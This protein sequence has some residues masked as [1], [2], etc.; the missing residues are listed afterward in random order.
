MS[1]DKM[2]RQHQDSLTDQLKYL[3]PI[4][5][6][7]GMYDAA[8]YMKLILDGYTP[9]DLFI[10]TKW[11]L[12]TYVYINDGDN[13][14]YGELCGIGEEN[15]YIVYCSKRWYK[16]NEVYNSTDHGWFSSKHFYKTLEEA[17]NADLEV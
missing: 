15:Y 13:V 14:F 12:G 16:G 3:I 2:K 9:D 10:F 8:D 5:N 4:A 17:I 11:K 1:I 6:E 7:N